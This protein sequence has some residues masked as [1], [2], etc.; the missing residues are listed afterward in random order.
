MGFG[1]PM[2]VLEVVATFGLE[3]RPASG[4]R[5]AGIIR[6]GDQGRAAVQRLL[7]VLRP[8]LSLHMPVSNMENLNSKEYLSIESATLFRLGRRRARAGRPDQDERECHGHVGGCCCRGPAAAAAAPV[9]AAVQQ[10]SRV[11][12]AG[13]GHGHEPRPARHDGRQGAPGGVLPFGRRRWGR[14][15]GAAVLG[16]CSHGGVTALFAFFFLASRRRRLARCASRQP[17]AVRH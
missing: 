17:A 2:L 7:R 5:N 4:R 13:R 10:A 9:A 8:R 16:S 11:R 6:N 14:A 1:V 15:G 12:V 3:E